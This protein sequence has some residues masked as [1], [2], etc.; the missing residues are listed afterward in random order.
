MSYI[1]SLKLV[2]PFAKYT[3]SVY[4]YKETTERAKI[5]TNILFGTPVTDLRFQI[6]TQNNTYDV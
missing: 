3:I 4:I 2:L 1:A 5:K 6:N